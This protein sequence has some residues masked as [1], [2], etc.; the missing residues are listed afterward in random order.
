MSFLSNVTLLGVSTGVT[1]GYSQIWSLTTTNYTQLLAGVAMEI[2]SNSANDTA[3]GTGART[4][5]VT[6]VDGNYLPFSE[7]LTLN[8]LAA[9][10]LVN[11]SVIGINFIEVLTAGSGGTNAGRVDVRTVSGSTVKAAVRSAADV[12]G[13]SH[14]FIYTVPAGRYAKIKKINVTIAGPAAGYMT[15]CLRTFNSTGAYKSN[16]LI[17]TGLDL[18]GFQTGGFGFDY[19]ADGLYVPEKT[20]IQ[21]V[22]AMSAGSAAFTS[23][24]GEVE[25]YSL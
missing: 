5:R 10:P 1:T 24:I 22:G 9:V 6:G 12:P 2:I 15:L 17:G 14:D 23:A 20:L 21:L 18:T 25:L 8:G 7:V 3:A 13:M 4:V 19:G 16:G 11:T